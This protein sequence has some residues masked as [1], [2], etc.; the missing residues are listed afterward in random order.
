MVLKQALTREAGLQL[1]DQ[2]FWLQKLRIPSPPC[3]AGADGDIGL[4][5]PRNFGRACNSHACCSSGNSPGLPQPGA[6][7]GWPGVP[8]PWGWHSVCQRRQQT[9]M[10]SSRRQ[11]CSPFCTHG[12]AAA[13]ALLVLTRYSLTGFRQCGSLLQDQRGLGMGTLQPPKPCQH[14]LPVGL[15]GVWTD[16]P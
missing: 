14:L 1:A 5:H 11:R 8:C 9:A 7:R 6:E 16:Q 4:H 3:W 12:P 2:P 13:Q 10:T 15:V